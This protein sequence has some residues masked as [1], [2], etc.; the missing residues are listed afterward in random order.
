MATYSARAYDLVPAMTGHKSFGNAEWA[1]AALITQ[2][3][4]GY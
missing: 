4:R 2:Q 3:P 1:S